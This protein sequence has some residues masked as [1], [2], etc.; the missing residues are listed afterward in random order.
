MSVNSNLFNPTRG[1]GI[2]AKPTDKTYVRVSSDEMEAYLYLA[3][4]KYGEDYTVERLLKLLKENKVIF[5][6]N[7]KHLKDIIKVQ[8]YQSEILVAKGLK[9]VDGIKGR[10]E[11][12]FNTNPSG[13]PLIREDGSV[14]Y[15]SA[16]AVQT[17]D[18]GDVIA[19]YKPATLGRMGET[20]TGKDIEP[21]K[22]KELLPL[23]GKGFQC[24]EDGNTYVATISGK[25][26][27]QNNRIMI[28]NLLEIK[29]DLDYNNGKIDFNSDVVIY[30][31]VK[32]TSTIK[33]G[34]SVTINGNVGATTII[35]AKDI[36]IRK[37]MQGGG[38]AIIKSGGSVYAQ[39]IE[40]SYVEAKE[41]IQT[42]ILM[43]CTVRAGDNILV[44]GKKATIIGGS[45]K[46]ASRIDVMVAGNDAEI[47]TKLAVGMDDEARRR[48]AKIKVA[49]QVIDRK[50]KEIDIELKELQLKYAVVPQ[51]AK[52][53]IKERM[54]ELIRNKIKYT[55]DKVEFKNELEELEA[56]FIKSKKACI[57]VRKSIYPGVA[58]QINSASRYLKEKQYA[59][60]YRYM[61]G[62]IMCEDLHASF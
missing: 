62:E 58:I 36:I 28:T 61:G 34:G 25:I 14:D 35:A 49:F 7:K 33:S 48:I 46:A 31:D 6:I 56:N 39:F 11:Y 45:V 59:M 17:V 29:G 9:S 30:G 15:Q 43:N 10:Y 44:A 27:Y 52:V 18:K 41:D 3:V 40:G 55:S 54:K 42:D 16:F 24:L 51:Y 47:H 50:E 2:M 8:A 12:K 57:S 20:V 21:K 32:N 37:G 4:P 60:E 38:K 53:A 5:G 26:V 13:K 23:K 1:S 22:G 19:V